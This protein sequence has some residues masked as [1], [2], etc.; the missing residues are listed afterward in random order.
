MT[1]HYCYCDDCKCELNTENYKNT[2]E[3]S[4]S[5][6]LDKEEIT[7]EN[8]DIIDYRYLRVKIMNG[9]YIREYETEQPDLCPTCAKQFVTKM[10]K[11]INLI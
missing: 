10:L 2:R 4:A 9:D 8:Q 5:L 3:W 11:Q 7:Q 6:P 1:K